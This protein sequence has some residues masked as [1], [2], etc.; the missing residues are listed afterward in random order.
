MVIL[1]YY[2]CLSCVVKEYELSLIEYEFTYRK[3]E[4][5]TMSDNQIGILW[6]AGTNLVCAILLFVTSGWKTPIFTDHAFL[7]GLFFLMITASIFVVR[8]GFFTP[9]ANSFRKVYRQSKIDDEIQEALREK[10]VDQART[11]RASQIAMLV[12]G[13][14]GIVW[15]AV[16][17]ISM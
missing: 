2:N 17:L 7:L 14:T 11:K 16:S 6:L 5:N 1:V 3:C 4:R 9:I 8:G 12:T 13:V 15:I 10:K